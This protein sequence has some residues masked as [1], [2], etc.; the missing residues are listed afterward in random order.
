MQVLRFEQLIWVCTSPVY[1]SELLLAV[2]FSRRY[3]ARCAIR[4]R[5]I[6]YMKL[7]AC[8][9]SQPCSWCPLDYGWSSAVMASVFWPS[10]APYRCMFHLSRFDR[11]RSGRSVRRYQYLPGF[12]T[13]HARLFRVVLQ[14]LLRAM[15][16][17]TSFQVIYF[18]TLGD[19]DR[20][21]NSSGWLGV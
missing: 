16:R 18:N 7:E 13:W 5:C 2:S 19:S 20:N 21:S 12:N 3:A 14:T 1:P 6:E 17:L 9:S 4:L 11:V 15:P 8:L 10:P